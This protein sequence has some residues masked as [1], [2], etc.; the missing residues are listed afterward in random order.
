MATDGP[1]TDSLRPKY[2][3]AYLVLQ[4]GMAGLLLVM[5]GH[6]AGRGLNDLAFASPFLLLI[7]WWIVSVW[8]EATQ[9]VAWFR[10]EEDVLAYRLILSRR[11]RTLT[12]TDIRR[13]VPLWYPKG[14]VWPGSLRSV[15]LRS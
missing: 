8:I 4:N 11:E 7:G 12:V 13:M 10:L 2:L 14:R 15:P 9:S 3:V 5:F 6:A 1:L